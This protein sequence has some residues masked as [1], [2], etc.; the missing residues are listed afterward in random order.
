MISGG[1][2]TRSNIYFL[3]SSMVFYGSILMEATDSVGSTIKIVC[4]AAL[5]DQGYD[6]RKQEYTKG[7]EKI[8]QFGFMPYIV[9]SCKSGPSFLDLLSDKVW[10]AKTNDF[11]LRNKGVNEVK[12]LL[13]FFEFNKFDDDDI[14][15]KTTARYIFTDNSFLVYIINHPEYDAFVKD[16][17]KTTKHKGM[18]IFT[19]CFAMKYKYFIDFL[20]HLNLQKM[21][22]E[23]VSIEWELADYVLLRRDMRTCVL[24]TLG[25]DARPAFFCGK[26]FYV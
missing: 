25:M 1:H 5:I 26:I 22:K 7:I 4:T 21:E 8:K 3:M 12:S 24:D 23:M 19:G 13:H 6:S 9:E 15:V 20:R 10:Y 11:N 16:I 18:D 2:A 17:Q 14:I